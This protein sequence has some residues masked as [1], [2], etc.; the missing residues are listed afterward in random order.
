MNSGRQR[1]QAMIEMAIGVT[2]FLA[3]SLGA[4]QLGI[5]AFSTEGVQS[6]A[7]VGARAA[8]G[9]PVPGEPL[10][11]LA[12]GQSAAASSLRDAVLQLAHL[13]YCSADV[14]SSPGCGLPST[15]VHYDGEMPQLTTLQACPSGAVAVPG[16][17]SLGPS[18][19]NLDGPQ[20]PA[21]H[22]PGCFGVARAMAPCAQTPGPGQLY[23]CLAYTS[24]PA[25]AVDIWIKG[26]LR[27]V[28]PVASSAGI[29]ALPVSVQLRLQVEAL[30]S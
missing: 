5:S 25:T 23:V 30:T 10:A 6:A 26:A 4:V 1:G 21:C 2:I 18:P 19:D 11:R 12:E 27:S 28:V 15:C 24:W 8:A 17:P 20:N 14:V 16:P 13:H 22:V 29:D 7:L 9:V 3:A